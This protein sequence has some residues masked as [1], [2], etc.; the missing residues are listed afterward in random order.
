MSP[1]APTGNEINFGL[2][3]IIVS[4][5]DARGTITYANRVF[6][7]VAGY[8]EEEVIGKPHNLIR[9]PD[10]PRC[11][12]ALMWERLKAGHEIFAY[13]KNMAR[14]GDHYWVLAHVTPTKDAAGNVT[15]YH[16][17]R[18]SP[19]RSAVDAIEPLY[20]RLREEERLYPNP[21]QAVEAGKRLLQQILSE[22]GKPYDEFICKI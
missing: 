9:H 10:M 17:N 2:E 16:S 22:K 7:K 4:K 18:R 1:H 15:N 13:V 19:E 5:T 12:F 20:Q 14:N 3:E 11:I 6:L 21:K 8:Q